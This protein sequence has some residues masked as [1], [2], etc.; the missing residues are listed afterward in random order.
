MATDFAVAYFFYPVL[1]CVALLSIF[2]WKLKPTEP[3]LGFAGVGG[4]RIMR[5][6]LGVVLATLVYSYFLTVMTGFSKVELGHIEQEELVAWVPPWGIY[7]FVLLTPFVLFFLTA[8]GLPLLALLSRYRLTSIAGSIGIAM[9]LP[10][11]YALYTLVNPYNNWCASRLNTC[12]SQAFFSCAWPA[13]LMAACF[14][15]FAGLPKWRSEA[16]NET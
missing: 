4:K 2:A 14:A 8:V 5:G 16:A 15:I 12:V 7:M 11:V 6:Y 9:V 13:I 10:F 1:I 3:G